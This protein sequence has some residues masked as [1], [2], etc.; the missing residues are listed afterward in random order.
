MGFPTIILLLKVPAM[1]VVYTYKY[2]NYANIFKTNMKLV[3][4]CCFKLRGI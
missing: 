3:N 4:A 2:N 1:Y